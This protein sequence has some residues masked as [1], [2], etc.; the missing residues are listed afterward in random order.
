[1][2]VPAETALQ[3]RRI[4]K[5]R[6]R[7]Q[8]TAD[9]SL[10]RPGRRGV[11]SR[12]AGP[13]CRRGGSA[14]LA[15][16]VRRRSPAW[17]VARLALFPRWSPGRSGPRGPY[18]RSLPWHRRAYRGPPRLWLS[19]CPGRC[20][21]ATRL[22]LGGGPPLHGRQ[23]PSAPG[24]R[25]SRSAPT[26]PGPARAHGRCRH[27]RRLR[28]GHSRG[29]CPPWCAAAPGGIPGPGRCWPAEHPSDPGQRTRRRAGGHRNG[30][31]H[32]RRGVPARSRPPRPPRPPTH[33]C[34]QRAHAHTR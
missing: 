11:T 7:G 16:P 6:P 2:P 23:R 18:A 26:I 34:R 30:A 29:W 20:H 14:G 10:P 3:R 28:P 22:R 13:R 25:L 21:R 5:R 12:W 15:G 32:P 17:P 24:T 33:A 8:T 4:A 19:C 1:M 27:A 31:P 9:P